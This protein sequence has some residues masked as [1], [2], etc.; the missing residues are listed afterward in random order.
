MKIK[1]LA[2]LLASLGLLASCG[3]NNSELAP[4]SQSD[5]ALISQNV[6]A[7]TDQN[8][9]IPFIKEGHI[10]FDLLGTTGA[11]FKY[12][13]S[14][15]T[16]GVDLTLNNDFAVSFTGELTGDDNNFIFA[17]IDKEGKMNTIV[18]PSIL[19]DSAAEYVSTIHTSYLKDAKKAYV[20]ISK[21]SPTWTQGLNEQLDAKLRQLVAL[22]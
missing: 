10:R 15:I 9:L 18:N 13:T 6:S 12:G 4:I 19:K 20:A 16:N 7:P 1:S 5:S 2:I 17:Y 14:D 3:S 8:D 22:H 11:L 21:G